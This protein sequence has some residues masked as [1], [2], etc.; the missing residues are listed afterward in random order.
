MAGQRRHA[1]GRVRRRPPAD[2]HYGRIEPLRHQRDRRGAAGLAAPTVRGHAGDARRVG[3]QGPRLARHRQ[4]PA[5]AGRRRSGLPACR[6]A[7]RAA[8]RAVPRPF[9]ARPRARHARER[10]RG[11]GSH[12]H[13]LR[14]RGQD[15]SSAGSAR[16]AH[17]A[18]GRRC[19][20]DRPSP[21]TQEPG[22]RNRPRRARQSPR[23]RQMVHG[24][25]R[26][27]ISHRGGRAR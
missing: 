3:R 16:G 10:G 4:R 5:A 13:R 23:A 15:Q 20:R 2:H 11:T 22:Q 12:R 1:N 9:R 21:A 19:R 7:L 18:A 24:A 27:H 8:Q 6:P 26:P 14:R 17:A 25:R